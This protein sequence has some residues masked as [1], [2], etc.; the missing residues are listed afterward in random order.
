V[1]LHVR[2]GL[3]VDGEWYGLRMA[4]AESR[5]RHLAKVYGR[6]VKVVEKTCGG[7]GFV[8]VFSAY[9]HWSDVKE[10]VEQVEPPPEFL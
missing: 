5:A 2:A 6:T 7:K 4:Q 3:Y 10:P 9:G 1:V 8:E